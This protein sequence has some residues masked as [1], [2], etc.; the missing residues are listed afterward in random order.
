MSFLH[1]TRMHVCVCFEDEDTLGQLLVKD[2]DTRGELKEY[3]CC[4][5]VWVFCFVFGFCERFLG[6]LYL[7]SQGLFFCPA[8]EH[9][10]KGVS[11][12]NNP[13]HFWHS[14]HPPERKDALFLIHTKAP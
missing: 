3:F 10:A 7:E 11:G 5:L 4:C 9:L 2:E 12:H 1:F 8:Q 14:L 6:S 13:V